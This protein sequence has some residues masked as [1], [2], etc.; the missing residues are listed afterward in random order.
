MSAVKY[1]GLYLA[2]A[3][4]HSNALGKAYGVKRTCVV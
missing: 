2:W 1:N 4:L 3:V